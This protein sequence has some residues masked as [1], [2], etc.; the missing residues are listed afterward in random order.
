MKEAWN[1]F[2]LKEKFEYAWKGGELVATGN[3][4]TEKV[5]WLRE[6][7]LYPIFWHLYQKSHPL[8]SEREY[9]NL[10]NFM[11][12]NERKGTGMKEFKKLLQEYGKTN[13]EIAQEVK[14]FTID[15]EVIHPVNDFGKTPIEFYAY[16][17]DYDWVVFCWL[18]G[19]MM[20]LPKGFPMYCKDLKQMM[21]EIS[22]TP[23]GLYAIK[24]Q[25]GYR[26][27]ELKEKLSDSKY[28][29]EQENEHSAIDDA[30]WNKKLYEFLKQL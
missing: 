17:A 25:E 19:N 11:G 27:I 9:G 12:W 8:K 16:Y 28:Y 23:D 6:N 1:R 21:D 22:K 4:I 29:P 24:N 26:M 30:R 20:D 13:K 2:D 10:G 14:K 3:K 7:V 18:F 15:V 5:Y